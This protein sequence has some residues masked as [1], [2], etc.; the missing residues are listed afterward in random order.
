MSSQTACLASD[1]GGTLSAAKPVAIYTAKDFTQHLADKN[2]SITFSGVGGHHHNGV[3]EN[4]IKNVVRSARTMMI[5]A[6]LRWPEKMEKELW[7]L[8]LQHSVYLLNN[9]KLWADIPSPE[10]PHQSNCASM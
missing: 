9:M 4:A 1:C 2:Q 10:V 3:A 5:H 7:P 6:A 8:A